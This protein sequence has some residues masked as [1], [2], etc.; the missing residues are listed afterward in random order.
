LTSPRS[1]MQLPTRSILLPVRRWRGVVGVAALL[2]TGGFGASAAASAVQGA[3]ATRSIVTTT[4][5]GHVKGAPAGTGVGL[6]A[7][8]DQSGTG[9]AV[10]A[11]GYF[12]LRDL[13]AGYWH[14]TVRLPR[15][16]GVTS[17]TAG[18]GADRGTEIDGHARDH[19]I[20]RIKILAGGRGRGY[21]FAVAKT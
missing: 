11:H 15:G 20:F 16:Y 17:A 6:I 14:L 18:R 10:N 4:L 21:D 7:S 1:D 9:A 8:N 12:T 2:A 13:S 5:S 19:V 3:P